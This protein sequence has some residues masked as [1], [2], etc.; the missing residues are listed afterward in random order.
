MFGGIVRESFLVSG[1]SLIRIGFWT[2]LAAAA[3]YYAWTRPI[4]ATASG[5][6]VVIPHESFS[7]VPVLVDPVGEYQ[8]IVDGERF[9]MS[10]TFDSPTSVMIEVESSLLVLSWFR[11]C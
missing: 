9:R 2:E 8:L 4:E 6:E 3:E 11:E 7:S 10:E 1:D 5:F